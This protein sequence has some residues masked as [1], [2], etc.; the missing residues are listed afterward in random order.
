MPLGK[1]PP[2]KYI[3]LFIHFLGIFVIWP[4]HL[5]VEALE[6]AT[7]VSP[8]FK[9][10]YFMSPRCTIIICIALGVL[11]VAVGPALCP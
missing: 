8:E 5:I 2:K 3:A 6:S 1:D 7:Y 10:S 11:F 4:K 9:A